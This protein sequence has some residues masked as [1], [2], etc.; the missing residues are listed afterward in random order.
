[1]H[2]PQPLGHW[3]EGPQ[4][5]LCALLQTDTERNVPSR[6]CLHPTRHCAGNWTGMYASRRRASWSCC[7]GATTLVCRRPPRP[8]SHC[9]RPRTAARVQCLA[10]A[11]SADTDPQWLERLRSL[12]SCCLHASR[13]SQHYPYHSQVSPDY[14]NHPQCPQTIPNRPQASVLI[15]PQAGQLHASLADVKQ[16]C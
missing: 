9:C 16:I 5:V 10:I 12:H 14:P 1:M 3:H 13:V 6:R 11:A 8:Q 2:M 4:W 15:H 7:E